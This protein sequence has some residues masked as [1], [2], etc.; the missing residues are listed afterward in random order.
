MSYFKLAKRYHPDINPAEN[1]KQ[2][3]E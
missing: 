1:A 2:K 3:F